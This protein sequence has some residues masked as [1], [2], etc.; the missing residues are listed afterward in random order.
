MSMQ[1][2]RW[3]ARHRTHSRT[4]AL[5]TLRRGVCCALKPEAQLRRLW[6]EPLRQPRA[7]EQMRRR[8][9]IGQHEERQRL[10]AGDM[11]SRKVADAD[12]R[13]APRRDDAVDRLGTK[14]RHPQQ[15]LAAGAV[16]VEREAIAIA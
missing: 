12:R 8:P 6:S 15:L 4:A 16:D 2:L 10:V 7:I 13:H 11:Q 1:C 9:V 3:W 5:P 14:T